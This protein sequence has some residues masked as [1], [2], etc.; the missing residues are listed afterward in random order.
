RCI[1]SGATAWNSR[2]KASSSNTVP[3]C[4]DPHSVVFASRFRN[5]FT[6]GV[7]TKAQREWR[8][9]KVPAAGATHAGLCSKVRWPKS[10]GAWCADEQKQN[11]VTAT[12][13]QLAR[14]EGRWQVRQMLAKQRLTT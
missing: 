10:A 7:C 13:Q 8:A 4:G 11:A 14:L 5:C 1:E 2:G 9:G 3:P 6:S 12:R